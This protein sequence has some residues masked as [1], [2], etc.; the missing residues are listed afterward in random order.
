MGFMKKIG[1]GGWLLVYV[2]LNILVVLSSVTLL[3]FYRLTDASQLTHILD[4]ITSLLGVVALIF[5]FMFSK[6]SHYLE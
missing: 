6:K 3:L 2:I 5:I 1:I 4:F